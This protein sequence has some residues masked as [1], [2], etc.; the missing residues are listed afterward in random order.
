MSLSADEYFT[1]VRQAD[2]AI[3]ARALTLVESNHPRDQQMAEMLLT[4]LMPFTGESMRV[5]ITGTPGVGK[6]TL[7]EALGLHLVA[8][9]MRVAVLAIDPSSQ[10]TGGSILA[11]KARMSRLALEPAAYIRP[12]PSDGTLGGVARKTRECLLVCEAAG[13]DVVFVETIGVGQSESLVAEVT[14]CLLMLIQ[15]GAG[16]ELQAIKRGLLEVVDVVAVNKADGN[17]RSAAKLAVQQYAQALQSVA[18]GQGRTAP[19]VLECSALCREG[20]DTLWDAMKQCFDLRAKSG[21]LAERRRQQNLRWLWRIVE[22]RLRQ[23]LFL[24]PV[25]AARR[26]DLEQQVLDGRLPPAVAAREILLAFGV[27]GDSDLQQQRGSTAC[28]M[29]D[30]V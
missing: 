23:A 22:D 16:D 28:G 12:S 6:S 27:S 10:R 5:G 14:D 19:A 20:I 3:L 8:R 25:V 17:N 29:N 9:G 7:I 2:V 24:H 13:Y 15:P 1:G 30:H 26:A 18:S 11:D 21:G 4:R